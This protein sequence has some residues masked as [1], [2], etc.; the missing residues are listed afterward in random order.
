M[1]PRMREQRV[2]GETKIGARVARRERSWILAVTLD[3]VVVVLLCVTSF[4]GLLGASLAVGIPL[5]PPREAL[6]DGYYQLRDGRRLV[7]HGREEM[8]RLRPEDPEEIERFVLGMRNEIG[9]SASR[10]RERFP[11]RCSAGRRGRSGADC[12]R[13]CGRTCVPSRPAFSAGWRCWGSTG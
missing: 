2:M 5:L 13:C 11:W 3:V 12:W 9:R 1:V 7:F 6:D 8:E 10:S 4:A